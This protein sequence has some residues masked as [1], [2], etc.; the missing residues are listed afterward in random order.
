[1]PGILQR[2]DIKDLLLVKN[3]SNTES[4]LVG[5]FCCC[6]IP[7]STAILINFSETLTTLE[8][9]RNESQSIPGQLKSPT[10]TMVAL[11]L[12]GVICFRTV[13]RPSKEVFGELSV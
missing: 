3:R 8:P 9:G 13:S 11:P 7:K 4:C 5:S 2:F 10:T 1:M 6:S 12:V